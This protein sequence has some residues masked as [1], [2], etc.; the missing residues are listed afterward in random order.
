[1]VALT[2][3]LMGL[4]SLSTVHPTTG[5]AWRLIQGSDADHKSLSAGWT[6]SDHEMTLDDL[7]FINVLNQPNNYNKLVY[8]NVGQQHIL[9]NNLPLVVLKGDFGS[10]KKQFEFHLLLVY[11]IFLF[12]LENYI[13]FLST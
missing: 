11:L 4:S 5:S 1:M 8:Y 13:I 10:G 2:K 12:Q 6:K 9:A 3:V 7:T